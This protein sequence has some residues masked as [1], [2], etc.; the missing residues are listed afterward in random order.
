MRH[1][2]IISNILAV[3]LCIVT[4]TELSFAGDMDIITKNSIK[5]SVVDSWVAKSAMPTKRRFLTSAVVD[6]K[7]Y[8]I[9]GRMKEYTQPIYLNT[10]EVYDPK[11]DTWETKKPM[12]TKRGYLTSA[13]VDGKIYC[14]GGGLD[15][16]NIRLNTVEVYDPKTD[17]WETK[18]PMP[19]GRATLISGVVN[20]KIYCMGGIGG[21][22]V[23]E[24]YD[25]KTDTWET[26]RPMPNG[27]TDFTGS[28]VNGKIYC[29]GGFD[30]SYNYISTTE[31]YDPATDTWTTKA[32]TPTPRRAFTS[33]AVDG[34]IYCAGG[35]NGSYL[36]VVEVYDPATDR[37]TKKASIPG[38][39]YALSSAVVDGK[40]YCI[41]GGND[42]IDYSEIRIYTAISEDRVA[43]I[44]AED[45][46]TK[47]KSTKNYIDIEN[48]RN[49]I[50]QL[51]ENSKRDELTQRLNKIEEDFLNEVIPK[52]EQAVEK[53]EGT[54][55]SADI[56]DARN[57]V[58]QLPGIPK[59]GELNSR[60][61]TLEELITKE[62]ES[63][64]AVIKAE[65]S[66]D[67][68]D[69]EDARDKVNALPDISTKKEGLTDR[70]DKLEESILGEGIVTLKNAVSKAEQTKDPIDI[71]YAR[72][73]VNKLDEGELK[74]TLQERLDNISPIITLIVSNATAN[75]DLYIKSENML[76][77][78]LNTNSITFGNYTG[79]EDLTKENAVI[80]TVNSSLPYKVNASLV[81]EIKSA[82]NETMDS[83]KLNIKA[84]N[85][86]EDEYK[87]FTAVNTAIEVVGLQTTTGADNSHGIDLRI[88]SNEAY[89]ADVYKTT[90]KFEA[91]QS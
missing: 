80:L 5:S 65:Q 66:K 53:A 41:G 58:N 29:I 3:T 26:K 34:K 48:A 23:I 59:K 88:K 36:D 51:P 22:D 78:S 43:E 62:Q 2:K 15:A 63:E 28:V 47:A 4:A 75:L 79:T 20:G 32:A 87:P 6:G 52:A 40:M 54:K 7:I 72:D 85:E 42:T 31:V 24:V 84:H 35:H 45:A 74:D 13:V 90:I 50:N 71:E 60:L 18:K 68:A 17:T 57:L 39:M 1:K 55:D 69:I 38:K 9:G 91:T 11:T 64:Q 82:S 21:V 89:K 25:P 8:C 19:T 77:M 30:K 10:V 16:G 81:S 73:L 83:D 12:P 44:K 86:P 67:F 76:S 49:L 70:L 14:I 56:E 37:W 61:N 33:S 27:R 46:V